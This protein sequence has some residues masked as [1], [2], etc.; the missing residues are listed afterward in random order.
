MATETHSE[1]NSITNDPVVLTS[2]VI[3]GVLTLVAAL[4]PL[5][6]GP[7][8][9][10]IVFGRNYLHDLVHLTTGIG[11]LAAGIYAGGKFARPYTLT[12]GVVYLL[13]T[14][15]GVVAFGLLSDLIALNVADNGLHLVLAIALLGIGLAFGSK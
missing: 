11:G 12:F 3:G 13:V 6:A 4:G 15:L 7:E 14:V 8:G 9:E 1:E 10:L 5:L 2:V